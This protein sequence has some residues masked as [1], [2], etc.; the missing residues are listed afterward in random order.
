MVLQT[1]LSIAGLMKGL[2]GAVI[3]LL[4][5]IEKYYFSEHNGDIPSANLLLC[6]KMFNLNDHHVAAQEPPFHMGFWESHRA[7]QKPERWT[8]DPK[9]SCCSS[10]Y[11]MCW[12]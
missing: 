8:L 7:D 6:L 1:P 10:R 11:P 9:A 5:D 3:P 2:P 4:R 12:D